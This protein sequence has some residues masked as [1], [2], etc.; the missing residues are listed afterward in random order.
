MP[1]HATQPDGNEQGHEVQYVDT[2]VLTYDRLRDTLNV[3]GKCNSFDL[4]LD[5]LG[6]ARSVVEAR[7]RIQNALEAQQAMAR[8]AQDA[9]IAARVR[10]GR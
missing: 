8:A 1:D 2:V 10:E 5:M 9:A 4:M 6:R 3:G 7:L